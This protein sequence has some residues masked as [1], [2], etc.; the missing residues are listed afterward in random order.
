MIEDA[1]NMGASFLFRKGMNC[2]LIVLPQKIP[3]K[4]AFFS[5]HF[6]WDYDRF[7]NF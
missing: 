4:T 2:I 5:D 1:P 3:S 6:E 7:R